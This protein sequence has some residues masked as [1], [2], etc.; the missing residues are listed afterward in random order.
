MLDRSAMARVY[1]RNIG[2]PKNLRPRKPHILK[3]IGIP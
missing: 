1:N 3:V 2:T